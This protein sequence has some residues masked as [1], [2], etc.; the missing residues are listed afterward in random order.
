MN[1]R[2]GLS[3][4]MWRGMRR[5]V[6][7]PTWHD[8]GEERKPFHPNLNRKGHLFLYNYL[9]CFVLLFVLKIAILRV[10]LDIL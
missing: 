5:A 2:D 8:N 10:S 9:F 1:A 4:E 6:G 7:P 3:L